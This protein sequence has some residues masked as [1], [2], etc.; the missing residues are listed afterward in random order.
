[1][2]FYEIQQIGSAL[3]NTVYRT[4]FYIVVVKQGG[5]APCGI[6][7][8]SQFLQLTGNGNYLEFIFISDRNKY[9]PGLGQFAPGGELTFQI[10]QSTIRVD[11]HYFA[12]GFHFRTQDNID[13]GKLYKRKH[14]LFHCSKR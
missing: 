9:T 12:G 5:S 8:K 6:Q 11:A 2:I 3:R 14:R 13:T 1:M 4:G 7:N 10:S